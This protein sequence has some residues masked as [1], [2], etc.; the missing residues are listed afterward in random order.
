MSSVR[1]LV[2]GHGNEVNQ[3]SST[4]KARIEAQGF[5]GLDDGPLAQIDYWLRLSPAIC[6][7]WAAVGTAT[8]HNNLVVAGPVCRTGRSPDRPSFRCT[9]QLWLSVR[10]AWST[11]AEVSTAPAF[12]MPDGD[13]RDSWSGLELSV[14]TYS[15]RTHPRLVACGGS[16]RKRQH[17]FLRAFFHLGWSSANR[18]RA[19]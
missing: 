2:N 8:E 12:G 6:M 14:R 16:F 5:V 1:N 17:W 10:G 3:I 4:A 13:G 9:L 15:G 11:L 7:L 19:P 18:H